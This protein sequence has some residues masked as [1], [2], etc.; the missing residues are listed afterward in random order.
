MYSGSINDKSYLAFMLENAGRLGINKVRFV[1]DRGFVTEDNIAY[2]SQNNYPFIVPFPS[3]RLEAAALIDAHA[4]SIRKAA[5]RIREF[6]V[7]GA[8][9]DCELYGIR[10]KAHIFF[11]PE[12]QSVDEKELYS[13]IARLSAE[14]EKMGKTKRIAKRYTDFFIVSEKEKPHIS[15]ETDNDKID[16]RLKRAGYLVFLTTDLLCSPE[17]L[18]RM[19]RGRDA[20][21]KNFDQLKNGLDFR[22]LR[23][24]FNKTTEGKVFVGFLALVVR[25][26]LLSHV[27]AKPETKDLTL[28]KVLIE[29][30]KI[31]VITMPD[32]QKI[33]APL[34]RMQKTILSALAIDTKELMNSVS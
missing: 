23:T 16:E 27:K 31:K 19:Y 20:I 22:R 2:M 12:K 4:H 21:E 7:Y 6:D 32:T 29:L 9:F 11:D 3:A 34:T 13:R 14:L 18:I 26:Y 28:N 24:H 33:I 17:D 8:S 25:S 5:N 1:M 15:F 30:K 10:M